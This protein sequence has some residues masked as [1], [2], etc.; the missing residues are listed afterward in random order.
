MPNFF[1]G[2]SPLAASLLKVFLAGAAIV[3]VL[4]IAR[5]RGISRERI[6]LVRPPLGGT[7]VWIAIYIAY[8]LSTDLILHWRGPWD[9]APWVRQGMVV[10][11]LRVLA[12][13][14]LGPIAEELIFRGVFFARLSATR[15]GVWPSVV[16]LA[17]GWGLLH[18]S[19]S[20]GVIALIV[21]GGL[22]LG[23]ARVRTGS[24]WVPVLMHIAWNLYAVW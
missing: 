19:Y 15:L 16:I 23:A 24:V 10:S 22:L 7:V 1:A 8:F 17:I 11:V 20:G 6:G 5:V 12:V 3:A 2:M 21:A 9:F 18:Y 13:G 14:V 4:L